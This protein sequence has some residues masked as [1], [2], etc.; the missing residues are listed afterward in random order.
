MP[1][2]P[3][4]PPPPPRAARPVVARIVS[5]L[6]DAGRHADEALAAQG[7]EHGEADLPRGLQR[8]GGHLD[9]LAQF[10]FLGLDPVGFGLELIDWPTG[11]HIRSAADVPPDTIAHLGILFGPFVAGFGLVCV[12]CYSHYDLSRQRHQEILDGGVPDL[13]LLIQIPLW[14]LAFLVVGVIDHGAGTRDLRELSG[15]RRTAPVI[16]S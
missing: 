4:A 10:G 15:L 13:T 9:G 6:L 14:A 16:A 7:A 12:W 3:G 2:S 1:S 11:Q 8:F 5:N